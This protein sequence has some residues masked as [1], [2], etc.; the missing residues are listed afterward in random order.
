MRL[1]TA[2]SIATILCL[3]SCWRTPEQSTRTSPP[4]AGPS[5]DA[6]VRTRYAVAPEILDRFIRYQ[7]RVLALQAEMLAELSRLEV[8][9]GGLASA[10]LIR[11]QVEAEDR[12]RREL[13]LTERDVE[14]LDA[15]VGDV[16]SRR[17]RLSI[18]GARETLLEMEALA[19][20][21]PAE[22]RPAFDATLAALRRQIDES[23]GLA[24]ERERY[25]VDNVERVLA[26][27]TELTG[28]WNRAIDVFSAV[29]PEARKPNRRRR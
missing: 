1:A 24:D 22:E 18:D 14:E 5:G 27:E 4:R 15:I 28:Q 3:G 11:R 16:I 8:I 26:R 19:A 17:A 25:G 12:I 20:R 21:L 6:G 10:P 29:A 2:I 23:R 9:D 13:G 7:D